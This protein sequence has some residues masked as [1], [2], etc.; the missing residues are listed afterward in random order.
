MSP[1]S[2]RHRYHELVKATIYHL[3]SLEIHRAHAHMSPGPVPEVITITDTAIDIALEALEGV[4]AF[5]HHQSIRAQARLAAFTANA[6]GEF[7]VLASN[8]ADFRSQAP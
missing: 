4:N 6:A 1:S 7:E 5:V 2:Q 8:P 3:A